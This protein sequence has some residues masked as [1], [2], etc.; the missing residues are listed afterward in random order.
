MQDP[1]LKFRKKANWLRNKVLEMTVAAGAG[2][3]A[4]SF[5]SAEILVALYYGGILR[6]DPKNVKWKDR[7]RFVLSKGQ[8][9][10]SLYAVLADLGFF[11]VEELLTFTQK[12]S[13]LGG[14]TEDTIPGVEAFTGSL[15]HGLPIAA[16]LALGA[17]LNQQAFL[18]V[19]L[20]GDGECHEG[21]I[22]E[23]AMFAAQHKLNNLLAI[24]DSNGQS[25]TDFTESYLSLEPMVE[26][27]R[28]FGWEV[29]TANGHS[30]PELLEAMKDVHNPTY[31]KPLCIVADTIKGKG[32]SFMEKKPI[33]HYRI[34]VGEELD[35]AKKE[36]EWREE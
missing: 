9:A 20:L 35:I 10:V 24:V 18:T 11:P 34:P 23:A 14:H 17:R 5:S 7:D 31:E 33:W 27:W 26:K 12:G 1:L 13:R 4:P 3:I 6:V 36:L 30:V 28:A 8:A 29:R 19:A 15:G 22:W 25:A 32:V 16:G 21:S 2:H